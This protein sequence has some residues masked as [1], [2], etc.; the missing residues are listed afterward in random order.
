LQMGA[1]KQLEGAENGETEKR[2]S[3]WATC[4]SSDHLPTH[5]VKG[6]DCA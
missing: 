4:F 6:K 3:K 5:A 2:S 1:I